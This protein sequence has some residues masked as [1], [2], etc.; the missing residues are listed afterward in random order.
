MCRGAQ[1][2]IQQG[3]SN[4]AAGLG[5][6]EDSCVEETMYRFAEVGETKKQS[7]AAGEI[8]GVGALY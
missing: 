5:Y 2:S 8:A 6:P 3:S 4:I 1:F 7:L